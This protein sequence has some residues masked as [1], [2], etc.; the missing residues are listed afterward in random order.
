GEPPARPQQP[1]RFWNPQLRIRPERG[2]VLGEREIEGRVRE[3]HS[4]G[5]GL[6]ERELDPGL[7]LHSPRRRELSGGRIHADRSRTVLGETGREVRGPA[8]ELDDVPL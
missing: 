1:R 6:D 5:R 7:G 2:A 3:W 4:L 8:A